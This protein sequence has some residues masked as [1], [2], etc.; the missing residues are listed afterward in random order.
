MP[1]TIILL[2]ITAMLSLQTA[3]AQGLEFAENGWCHGQPVPDA[4]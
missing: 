4:G 3:F 2:L 1:R